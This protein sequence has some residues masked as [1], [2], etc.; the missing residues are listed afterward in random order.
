MHKKLSQSK[1][2]RS[3]GIR[4]DGNQ[5]ST[6]HTQPQDTL[7]AYKPST[8]RS[9]HQAASPLLASS[10]GRRHH[11]HP[12]HLPAVGAPSSAKDARPPAPAVA[13]S[14]CDSTPGR[15]SSLYRSW[16]VLGP[17][18]V[19]R[20]RH[21]IPANHVGLRSPSLLGRKRQSSYTNASIVEHVRLWNGL[22][23]DSNLVTVVVS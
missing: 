15:S 16:F 12:I 18:I 2:Q 8:P 4:N 21:S 11:H 13:A 3:A 20:G 14:C 22:T 7:Y 17:W 9:P 19:S 23:M 6:S 1:Y 5:I 10:A